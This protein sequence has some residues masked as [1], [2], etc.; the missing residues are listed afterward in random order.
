MT[1]IALLIAV[2]IV[3]RVVDTELLAVGYPIANIPASISTIILA[4]R[5]NK[6]LCT[7]VWS[8][9][10][11]HETSAELQPEQTCTRLRSSEEEQ[12]GGKVGRLE[13][14]SFP[15]KKGQPLIAGP[16]NVITAA[17]IPPSLVDP[18]NYPTNNS[19][20]PL[21]LSPFS[22]FAITFIESFNNATFLLSCFSVVFTCPIL[23]IGTGWSASKHYTD[24]CNS[25]WPQA[26]H[27]DTLLNYSGDISPLT[28]S[29]TLSLRHVFQTQGGDCLWALGYLIGVPAIHISMRQYRVS[30]RPRR[31][32]QFWRSLLERQLV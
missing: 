29:A 16:Q 23:N 28:I 26:V 25:A 27:L 18:H 21:F 3:V 31:E 6:R 30:T 20:F 9:W 8:I 19:H 24:Q 10:G 11:C 14:P 1:K 2:T 4:E 13:L 17:P 12:T 5:S 22:L 15:I 7:E 32:S